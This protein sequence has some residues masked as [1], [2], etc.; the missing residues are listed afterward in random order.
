M[1]TR[2][3][4]G[5]IAVDIDDTVARRG[6]QQEREHFQHEIAPRLTEILEHDMRLALISGNSMEQLCRRLKWLVRFLCFVDKLRLLSHVH[7]FCN[8][9]GVYARIPPDDEVLAGLISGNVTD[10]RE[11]WEALTVPS[12]RLRVL[13]PRYVDSAYLEKTKIQDDDAIDIHDILSQVA[14]GYCESLRGALG[15]ELVDLWRSSTSP[16]PG[17]AALFDEEGNAC[18]PLIDSRT[19][20]HGPAGSNALVQITLK[21]IASRRCFPRGLVARRDD[22]RPGIVSRIQALL[23]LK[24]LDHYT[25]RA[26]GRTS[27]DITRSRVDKA[28]AL[29]FIIDR[30]YLAHGRE[31]GSRTLYFGDEVFANGGN[32]YSVLRIP[33]LL[34][35]AVN[36]D[37]TSA[38]FHHNVLV[39]SD[40]TSGPPACAD[41]LAR[42][43]MELRRLSAERGR[44]IGQRETP[45]ATDAV[46]AFKAA[47]FRGR[48]RDKFDRVAARGNSFQLQCLHTFLTLL[49]RDDP[50]ACKLLRLVTG[51]L[52]DIV[53]FAL[54][55]DSSMQAAIG[56]S[57]PD[58]VDGRVPAMP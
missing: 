12:G 44:G 9:G 28:Y 51:Q 41:V 25:A 22:I 57:H 37:P 39:P 24:G 55:P 50:T 14:A 56:A 43:A 45:A 13:S 30:L 8:S 3:A 10:S 7:C 32:D 36:A 21:P 5:L 52:D 16:G 35:F 23:E 17:A 48:C 19:V 4:L 49:C 26:G 47:L 2:R 34:I 20:Q 31:V 29:E 46:E 53:D 42:L 11:A 58:S 38:P 1:S 15:R 54:G 33:G 6:D 40:V 27:I 18:P